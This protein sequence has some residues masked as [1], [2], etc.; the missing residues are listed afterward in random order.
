MSQNLLES[1]KRLQAQTQALE[2]DATERK[3]VRDRVVDYTEGFLG[4]LAESKAWNDSMGKGSGI[5][6]APITEESSSIENLLTLLE[7]EVN[8]PHLNAASGG[9]LAYIPSGGIYYASLADYVAS[10]I[11]KYASMF[12]TAPGAVRMENML[13]NWFAEVVGYPE[14]AAGNLTSGGSIANLTAII[15]ARD[16]HQLKPADYKSTVIYASP[17]MHHCLNRAIHVAG[18]GDVILRDL[19]LDDGH[20]VIASEVERI[21]KSDR[22]S[23]LKPWLMIASAGTTDVGAVDPLEELGLIAKDHQM[24]YHVDGAYGGLFALVDEIRHKFKG[25][26]LSDS[27][28]MDPHKGLFIPYG[29]GVVIVKRAENLV[30]PFDHSGNY[31]QD[32]YDL[33][34]ELSPCDISLELTKPF[35]ALRLWLPLKLA[36]LAPFRASLEEKLLLTRYFHQE[37]QKIDGFEAGPDPDL[38]IATFRYIDCENPDQFNKQLVDL[39]REDGRVFLSSTLLNGNYVIRFACLSFRTHLSQVDL[40]LQLIKE[41]IALLKQ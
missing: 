22:D 30:R 18:L 8:K 12:Y 26:E 1:I 14:G 37:I 35:R 23:G 6:N 29:T 31:M 27:V 28:V 39:I 36:G 24:W 40:L 17:Q 16:A 4:D 15:A 7:E 3:Q 10:I 2:P 41:K 13:I 25:I 5:Y 21:V 33:Q 20:R 9:H 34:E 19:P 11:N 38:S 32:A